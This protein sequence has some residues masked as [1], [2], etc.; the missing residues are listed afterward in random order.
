MNPE[1]FCQSVYLVDKGEPSTE[2]SFAEFDARCVG[3]KPICA[4]GAARSQRAVLALVGPRLLIHGLVFFLVPVDAQGCVRSE[5]NV[6]LD[7]LVRN[8]G[9]GPDLGAGPVVMACRGQ[10]PIPW[11]A[12]DL[13]D[14][15][16]GANDLY[17]QLRE[18]VQTNALGFA[19]KPIPSDAGPA[20]PPDVGAESP[21]SPD[22]GE[23][24]QIVDSVGPMRPQRSNRTA[25]FGDGGLSGVSGAGAP[26][27]VAESLAIRRQIDDL[28][29]QHATQLM[30][31]QQRHEQEL[32]S[33]AAESRMT[34]ELYR[35]EIERLQE[36]L[37][38]RGHR[39]AS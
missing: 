9:T 2:L 8:A 15:A 5:F 11:H 34:L 39:N 14:P 7:Y 35:K 3:K 18:R 29:N 23:Q 31:L 10:C 4:G 25:A 26:V 12:N 20:V 24:A 32:E 6:P 37:R 22:T 19:P 17:G 30:E 13:W 21:L 38:E 16:S 36:E 1:H 33:Q 27:S 28:L